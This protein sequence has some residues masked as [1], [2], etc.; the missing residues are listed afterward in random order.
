MY[1]P[2]IITRKPNKKEILFIS[3]GILCLFPIIN[4]PIALILGFI[5]VTI[6][7]VPS[8]IN[9][10]AWTKNL[11]AYSIVGLGFGINLDQAIEVSQNSFGLIVTSIFGLL[12]VGWI[13]TKLLN[14][15]QKTGYLISAGTAICGGSAIA[16]VSPSIDASEHQTSIA[17]AIVFVLNS[18]ALFVFPAIGHFLDMSQYAFGMWCAIA[19]HDTSSVVGAAS[20]Y[21]SEALSIAT[22]LKLSRA[23]WIVPVA[24]I[25]S[26]IFKSK[27]KKVS[28]PPFII[29]YCCAIFVAD[30][31]P[32]FS[33][34]YHIIFLASKQLLVVAL[35]LIG[36]SICHKKIKDAGIK[37]MI[38]GVT[39]WVLI[40][41]L[42]LT[43][44]MLFIQP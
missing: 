20:Q 15:D 21:G 13:L 26:F 30:L 39:L 5:L 1:I 34:I 44:I 28:V 37:P 9:T 29:L 33:E 35:F 38:L 3:A 27:D 24:L 23:L 43:Y 31:T 25:S 18:I 32:A 7:A 42:S 11:L 16:A 14:I 6:K 22:T 10:A 17:L 40:G 12:I 41:C 19:I 36:A 4:A 2:Q 8:S